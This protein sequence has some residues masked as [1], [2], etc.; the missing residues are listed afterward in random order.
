MKVTRVTV[1]YH[2]RW[3]TKYHAV[4]SAEDSYD[5][6]ALVNPNQYRPW[7]VDV[8]FIIAHMSRACERIGVPGLLFASLETYTKT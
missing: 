1:L 6:V 5:H 3:F 8:G 7:F 4:R 2:S